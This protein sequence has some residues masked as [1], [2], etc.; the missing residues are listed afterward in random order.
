V[1]AKQGFKLKNKSNKEVKNLTDEKTLD[2]TE[3]TEP[4]LPDEEPVGLFKPNTGITIAS[5]PKGTSYNKNAMMIVVFAILL[6]FGIV[7]VISMSLGRK[8]PGHS[9]TAQGDQP[10]GMTQTQ[11]LTPAEFGKIPGSYGRTT[12]GNGAIDSTQ[13][14][15]SDPGG[16]QNL[17]SS[18][19]TGNKNYYTDS[20]SN[21]VPPVQPIQTGQSSITGYGS[22]SEPDF[23]VARKSQIR[24]GNDNSSTAMNHQKQTED[25]VTGDFNKLAS[26]LLSQNVNPLAIQT[27]PENDPNLQDEKRNFSN[28]SGSKPSYA[29]SILTAPLSPYEIKAGTIVPVVL[30]TGLNS[31]LPG[32]IIAQ[33]RENVYDSTSGK[34]LLIPQGTK[35]IGIYDSKVAYAQSRALVNWSRMIFPNGYSLDLQNLSGIDPM[36]FTGLKDKVNNHTGKL[37]MGIFLTSVLGATVQMA[38]GSSNSLNPTY[39]ELAAQGASQ[40][41]QQAGNKIVQKDLDVQPT[42]EIRPGFKF[43]LSVDKDFVLQPYKR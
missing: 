17:N 30:I 42:L 25:G 5:P 12:G 9:P 18:N 33:V 15:P 11:D 40:A 26:Q 6:A 3:T 35:V 23:I 39:D 2:F 36:G 16:R 41:L 43:N 21:P 22:G 7:I 32:N 1:S 20:Y 29:T 10:T 37:V 19:S 34:F 8:K 38:G 13:P 24:F 4:A 27:Q 28:Q 31:D 14:V